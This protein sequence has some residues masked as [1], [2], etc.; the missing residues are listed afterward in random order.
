M[1]IGERNSFCAMESVRPD[2]AMHLW[3][4]L[5]APPSPFRNDGRITIYSTLGHLIH[6]IEELKTKEKHIGQLEHDLGHQSGYMMQL[7][8]KISSQDKGPNVG[9]PGGTTTPSKTTA[10]NN[11]SPSKDS[12]G[13]QQTNMKE[14][15]SCQTSKNSKG[16]GYLARKGDKENSTFL[17]QIRSLQQKISEQ[18]KTINALRQA[19][20]EK[21]RRIELIQHRKMKKR[22]RRSLDK[23]GN[24]NGDDD[25][26]SVD[27][28]VSVSSLPMDNG[29]DENQLDI[30]DEYA[31]EEIERS[32]RQLM[33]EHMDLKKSYTLL[34][35]QTASAMDP[36]REL[37]SCR[38]LESDLF[39]SQCKIEEL[40]ALLQSEGLESRLLEEKETLQS[41]N[42]EMQKKLKCMEDS[43]AKLQE[44]LAEAREQ[45]DDL[46]FRIL[47]LEESQN[48]SLESGNDALEDFLQP[49][50][51]A[52]LKGD[53]SVGSGKSAGVKRSLFSEGRG[54]HGESASS[55]AGGESSGEDEQQLREEVNSLRK[56][57]IEL[58]ERPVMDF[59]VSKVAQSKSDTAPTMHPPPPQSSSSAITTENDKCLHESQQRIEELEKIAEELQGKIIGLQQDKVQLEERL[60]HKSD[61]ELSNEEMKV[62]FLDNSM[63]PSGGT[64]STEHLNEANDIITPVSVGLS[65]PSLTSQSCQAKP[66]SD[67]GDTH[68]GSEEQSSGASDDEE[69]RRKLV[70]DS[71]KE[72]E[73]SVIVETIAE[74]AA[75]NNNNNSCNSSGDA[76]NDNGSDKSGD[77]NDMCRV[78]SFDIDNSMLTDTDGGMRDADDVDMEDD[79]NL[80]LLEQQS[81]CLESIKQI[82]SEQG[83]LSHVETMLQEME[84][85]KEENATLKEKLASGDVTLASGEVVYIDVAIEKLHQLEEL[86]ETLRDKVHTTE[87]SEILLKAKLQHAEDTVGELESS[88][89]QLKEQLSKISQRETEWKTKA[90]GLLRNVTELEQLLKEKD[91]IEEK[92][93]DKIKI[94]EE[95]E[96]KNSR[97]LAELQEDENLLR[98]SLRS[99]DGLS[100]QSEMLK[101]LKAKVKEL[102]KGNKLLKS[103]VAELEDNESEMS[104]H[105]NQVVQTD[106]NKIE[107]LQEKMKMLE[108]LNKELKNKLQEGEEE[109]M[110]GVSLA[111]ELSFSEDPPDSKESSMGVDLETEYKNLEEKFQE[112]TES[113]N[114]QIAEL[115]GRLERL[116]GTEQKLSETIAEMEDREQELVA[117][118]KLC[119]NSDFSVEKM[120]KYEEH[121]KELSSSQ[122]NLLNAIDTMV[123]PESHTLQ[124]INA[125]KDELVLSYQK[126]EQLKNE[127]NSLKGQIGKLKEND[128]SNSEQISCTENRKNSLQNEHSLISQNNK[129]EVPTSSLFV[130]IQELESENQELRA[131]VDGSQNGTFSKVSSTVS[132]NYERLCELEKENAE[133]HGEAMRLREA[134]CVWRETSEKVAVLES[135][136]EQLMEKVVEL[137]DSCESLKEELKKVR[138]ERKDGQSDSTEGEEKDGVLLTVEE[139]M[140]NR[141]QAEEELNISLREQLQSFRLRLEEVKSAYSEHERSKMELE[142]TL[143]EVTRDKNLLA[144][145]LRS[146][147][148]HVAIPVSSEEDSKQNVVN[149]HDIPELS[150]SD[151]NNHS[152]ENTT[153][154]PL[155]CAEYNYLALISSLEA[156]LKDI[157][158]SQASGEES[159]DNKDVPQSDTESKSKEEL[160]EELTSELTEMSRE[161]LVDFCKTLKTDLNK[162]SQKIEEFEKDFSDFVSR[163]RCGTVVFRDKEVRK[164]VHTEV[165]TFQQQCNCKVPINLHTTF[166]GEK[167]SQGVD[168]GDL[169]TNDN[170][171]QQ[172]Q[173]QHKSAADSTKALIEMPHSEYKEW[174]A[175][176]AILTD[177][178]AHMP[179]VKDLP[180]QLEL[181]LQILHKGRHITCSD[182]Q[183]GISNE[184][185]LDYAKQFQAI[186]QS[187]NTS[188]SPNG[189]GTEAGKEVTWVTMEQTGAG[190]EAKGS[191]SKTAILCNPASKSERKQV[192][193][194]LINSLPTQDLVL[195]AQIVKQRL[196]KEKV[197]LRSVDDPANNNNGGGARDTEEIQLDLWLSSEEDNLQDGAAD[198]EPSSKVQQSKVQAGTD[199]APNADVAIAATDIGVDATDA[200][201]T[202]T[203]TACTT[204]ATAPEAGDKQL[205]TE[206][207]N[208]NNNNEDEDDDDEWK[209]PLPN[210][211][212]PDHPPTL[213]DEP[214]IIFVDVTDDDDDVTTTDSA[215]QHLSDAEPTLSS[216]TVSRQQHLP[217]TTNDQSKQQVNLLTKALNDKNKYITMLEASI[218]RLGQMLAQPQ[219]SNPDTGVREEAIK[220]LEVQMKTLQQELRQHHVEGQQSLTS[221]RSQLQGSTPDSNTQKRQSFPQCQTERPTPLA[222]SYS[223]TDLSRISFSATDMESLLKMPPPMPLLTRACPSYSK[224]APQTFSRTVRR[225]SDTFDQTPAGGLNNIPGWASDKS[226]A[227]PQ[228]K[229]PMLA[230]NSLFVAASDYNP[231]LFSA[232]GHVQLELPLKEGDVIIKK[233]HVTANG[234]CEALVKG[235]VGLVP[236]K[237]L[238]PIKLENMTADEQRALHTQLR[239]ETATETSPDL[240]VR[241]P[242]QISPYFQNRTP[243]PNPP[244]SSSGS[245]NNNNQYLL[246]PDL[247]K[248]NNKNSSTT[249]PLHTTPTPITTVTPT[250]PQ[251]VK[252]HSGGGNSGGSSHI[253]HTPAKGLPEAPSN[254]HLERIVGDNSVLLSWHPPTMDE[255]D[256]NN[257]MQLIGYRIFLNG[258]LCQQ[259]GSAHLAKAVLENLDLS[260]PQYFA[261]QSVA[262]NGQMSPSA[263][264][265][266]LGLDRWLDGS[267]SEKDN[268]SDTALSD[269]LP[270]TTLNNQGPQRTFI[271]IYDYNPTV[272]SPHDYAEFELRFKA[273][274]KITVYGNQR[275]DGFFWAELNGNQGLVPAS[276][277]EEVPAKGSRSK[278]VSR[279]NSNASQKSLQA[280]TGRPST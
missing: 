249:P 136:E 64:T 280:T 140:K 275:S 18:Y 137:E 244:V 246:Q 145:K 181:L 92:L 31:R 222:H 213:L 101:T 161:Q 217:H 186:S 85:I 203:S 155:H 207:N 260:R 108:A 150:S 59:P 74:L 146:L 44:D 276:F 168:T 19:C 215:P 218:E 189:T 60:S 11:Y 195:V 62:E 165:K 164:T 143:E 267:G 96:V 133:L 88:E 50:T 48:T 33:R 97:K 196:A 75:G 91:S 187:L 242:T 198:N 23:C 256:Q 265:V 274:D 81:E 80:Q 58:T 122:V 205:G 182:G 95:S 208:Y 34:Q 116:Y 128:S 151:N 264:V 87:Q 28:E 131:K 202:I 211:P 65:N 57:I 142:K 232:S 36:E 46:E 117:K 110:T 138:G 158:S 200:D 226:P 257:G 52:P 135:N 227:L 30:W 29:T 197:T 32:Y 262:A 258:R 134:E 237:Y 14:S 70:E 7:E 273:G 216:V 45:I 253:S 103:K 113:K 105:W 10:Q 53:E 93:Y 123:D 22:L 9:S 49:I 277:V 26:C 251:F 194:E 191:S 148:K 111:S 172:Q 176:V 190:K 173:Q 278:P 76:S 112:V 247:A 179:N 169:L 225:R 252:R 16:S 130:R 201:A 263:E 99:K 63:L 104:E 38:A 272:Q 159:P 234:Y 266:F 27:S 223:T 180:H 221:L 78:P 160:S 43:E 170:T 162:K 55:A 185:L 220:K 153:N 13:N 86:C 41:A 114:N 106:A 73:S 1:N 129:Q 47:E 12:D 228:F 89:S 271:A 120:L 118:L 245:S 229:S 235:K 37:K 177:I 269:I 188:K 261:I 2:L 107:C 51:S 94:L 54:G 84:E 90:Q 178:E 175:K 183:V 127:T 255:L 3:P 5:Q 279:Q 109:F 6:V 239:G 61:V 224:L 82:L 212:P 231:D 259:P 171:E 66:G 250:T 139:A 15:S 209:P 248:W 125:L 206:A 254:F 270:T 42:V 119:E 233:G 69:R 167:M 121:I 56:Q 152:S 67:D 204:T 72:I 126:N 124:I 230:P 115:E 8:K 219:G 35:S 39:E 199:S 144:E 147:S 4:I 166:A 240:N 102:E 20:S 174:K 83:I 156:S 241:T 214:K 154:L 79:E 100:D 98:E 243:I 192:I 236:F 21:D 24:T 132:S 77:H 184:Q 68:E 163:I 141:L 71:W 17:A 268:E 210:S 238:H 40:K 157:G 149:N 193:E 25:A